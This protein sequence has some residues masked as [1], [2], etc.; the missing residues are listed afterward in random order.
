MVK[1]NKYRSFA[2]KLMPVV[3]AAT[4]LFAAITLGACR[5]SPYLIEAG[6]VGN[7]THVIGEPPVHV[8]VRSRGIDFDIE[9]VK[10]NFYFGHYRASETVIAN[11]VAVA[12]YFV[13]SGTEGG[14]IFWGRDGVE[15]FRDIGEG[16]YFIREICPIE[17]F[18]PTYEVTSR[19]WWSS[20]YTFST[21]E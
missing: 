21:S 19:G 8:G 14:R 11:T 5:E 20:R 2:K 18:T 16:V 7:G 12:L 9:S 4:M 3:L 10:L 1:Q 6:F 13:H 15:D 17:F